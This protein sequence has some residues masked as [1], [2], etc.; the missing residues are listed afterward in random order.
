MGR[1]AHDLEKHLFYQVPYH[2]SS[3]P[4][5]KNN[6]KKKTTKNNTTKNPNQWNGLWKTQLKDST[7]RGWSTFPR[8]VV[9]A[10]NYGQHV[11]LYLPKLESTGVKTRI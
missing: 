1:W 5:L 10:L 4:P 7:L 2:R 11:V 6:N 9:Y 8:D 3:Q